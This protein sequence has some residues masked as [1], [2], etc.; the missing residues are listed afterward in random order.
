MMTA[1]A[2]RWHRAHPLPRRANEAQRLLWHLEHQKCCGCRPMPAYLHARNDDAE[3]RKKK[4]RQPE[5][6]T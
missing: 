5:G 1:R 2:R 6:T 4:R 3:P